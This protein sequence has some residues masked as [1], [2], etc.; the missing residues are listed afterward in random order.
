MLSTPF[1]FAGVVLCVAALGGCYR[2]TPLT[3]A[4]APGMDLRVR[5]TEAG[6]TALAR[7]LGAGVA[8]VTGRVVR[9]DSAVVLAVSETER[10]G[11]RLSWGGEEVAIPGSAVAGIERRVLD[12][13]RT[14]GV[15]AGGAGGA[16]L[17]YLVIRSVG[18]AAS[19][20]DD[21]GPV[22]PPP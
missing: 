11:T 18:S 8:S 22:V 12:R 10:A 5:L 17:L 2:Y 21:G 7:Q 6:A 16:A 4:V 13:R 3:T 19:G 20:G 9:T 1:R 15:A 14:L